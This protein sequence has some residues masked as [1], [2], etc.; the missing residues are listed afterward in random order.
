MAYKLHDKRVDEE[1]K[2]AQESS[3]VEAY[4]PGRE[5]TSSFLP[6]RKENPNPL[7][8]L[9]SL[10]KLRKCLSVQATH[11]PKSMEGLNLLWARSRGVLLHF[12]R[13]IARRQPRLEFARPHL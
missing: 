9:K 11:L 6:M 7:R 5:V 10:S 4:F 13:V 12:H 1:S 3:L 2:P 8:E